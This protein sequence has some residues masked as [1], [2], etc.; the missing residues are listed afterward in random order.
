VRFV[1]WL[2]LLGVFYSYLGYPALIWLLARLHPRPW[3]WRP[4][5]P[6]VSIVLAV[7]NGAALLPRKIQHLLELDYPNI[8]EIILVSDGSTDGT[9][10]ILAPQQ[11]PRLISIIL[12][13]HG[14][15]AVAINAG[16]ARATAEVI[17]FVDIRPEIAPGAIQ[18]LVGNFADPTV[19]C[20][21]GELIL[22]QESH[23]HAS[24]AVSSLYWRYEKWIRSNES[25]FGSPVGVYGG[26]YAVRRAAAV[27]QPAGI[28]LDDMFQPLSIIRQGYRSVLDP[29]AFV[30]DTWPEKIGKEF[31]RKVRTL[32]GNFQL[33]QLAPWTL[34][35]RNPVLFQLLSHKVTR[36]IA[37]SLMI[38]LLVSTL[39]LSAAAP[40]Y[41]AFT[42]LQIIFWA[43]AAA[44]L[45]GKIP[46]LHRAAAP[47]GAMLVLLAAA[48]AGLYKFLFTREELWKIWN[49][50]PTSRQSHLNL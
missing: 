44:S 6:A 41:A 3:I 25:T 50:A 33:F 36:L 7:H 34:T 13:E 48:V 14:G 37:P 15:K 1:F 9:A 11:H 46:V 21:A 45:S 26:F 31:H 10:E 22:R 49:S 30:Y 23:D 42:G 38:S 39:A 4:I 16:M 17:L 32:A 8:Q 40:F 47:A 43:L 35:P 27:P 2:S 20:V 19:G 12:H 18:Q 24:A 28:I 5:S 29:Q